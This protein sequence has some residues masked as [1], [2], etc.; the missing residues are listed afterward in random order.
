MQSSPGVS[1]QPGQRKPEDALNL[2]FGK[3][4]NLAIAKNTPY[5]LVVFLDQDHDHR[6]G[7]DA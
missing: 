6:V 1:G 7:D 5:P 4:L 3:L 2:R